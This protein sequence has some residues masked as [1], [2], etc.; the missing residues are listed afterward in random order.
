MK[1]ESCAKYNVESNGKDPKFKVGDHVGIL[2][3]C[4]VKDIL[5]ICVKFW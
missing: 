1:P 2:K 4:L 5:L 3:K